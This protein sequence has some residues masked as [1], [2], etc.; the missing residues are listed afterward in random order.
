MLQRHR[1]HI[2][3][4]YLQRK[5]RCLSTTGDI[6]HYIST[7]TGHVQ[8][9]Y[10]P[11]SPPIVIPLVQVED[12]APDTW[13]HPGDPIHPR[14][15]LESLDVPRLIQVRPIH[16]FGLPVSVA[17]VGKFHQGGEYLWME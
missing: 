7:A 15:R 9:S 11:I 10:R 17:Q 4:V 6:Q 16:E 3:T 2:A 5:V 8:E 1:A 13:R 14:Q 12:F